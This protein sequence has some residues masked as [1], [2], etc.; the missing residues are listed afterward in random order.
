MFPL[1]IGGRKL[2]D[3]LDKVGEMILGWPVA[4]IAAS[5]EIS[6]FIATG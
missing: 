2:A 6:H 3:I 1:S 5:Y 4:N